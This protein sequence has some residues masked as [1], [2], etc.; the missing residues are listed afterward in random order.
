[1]TNMEGTSYMADQKGFFSKLSSGDFG[2][3]KTYWLY[4]V[5]VGIVINIV[6][7]IVPSIGA[8]AVVLA[9]ATVYQVMVLLGVWR[10]ATRYQGRKVWAILAKI[11]TVLGWM[12]VLINI[13][14]FFQIVGY[15]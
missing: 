14:V 1:M 11:A 13:G 8:I 9:L 5:V 10:A 12:G 6:I 3:P 15:L 2:L 4:G 7:Q